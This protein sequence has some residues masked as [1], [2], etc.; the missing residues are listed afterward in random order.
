MQV[1][2]GLLMLSWNQ[3]L[4]ISIIN[5][6]TLFRVSEAGRLD[7]FQLEC[8]SF[9]PQAF[10]SQ[11]HEIQSGWAWNIQVIKCVLPLLESEKRSIV[12]SEQLQSQLVFSSILLVSKFWYLGP[13]YL[14]LFIHSI[15]H[16]ICRTPL[17]KRAFQLTIECWAGI[18]FLIWTEKGEC[19]W[20]IDIFISTWN[21][22]YDKHHECTSKK[23]RIR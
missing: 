23:M 7:R 2:Y 5:T 6:L 11:L 3:Y 14:H 1:K 13:F 8:G 10:G 21:R 16:E 4:L 22:L 20:N 18:F 15:I 12:W 17:R 19:L 9:I